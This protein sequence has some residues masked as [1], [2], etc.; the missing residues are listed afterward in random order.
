M[1]STAPRLPLNLGHPV[2]RRS[3]PTNTV[4]TIVGFLFRPSDQVLVRWRSGDSSVEVLEDIVDDATASAEKAAL[5]AEKI[6]RRLDIGTLLKALPAKTN[7]QCGHGQPC[8]ACDEPI[9]L[10]QIE[11]GLV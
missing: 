1:P 10:A 5:I 6:R 4:G 7:T 3:D 2:H 9:A 8:D 11:Y